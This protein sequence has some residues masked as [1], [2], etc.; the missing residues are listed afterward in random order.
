MEQ[1]TELLDGKG[2]IRLEEVFGNE[3]KIVNAARRAYNR[4]ASEL[5][6]TDI[7]I[8]KGLL[9]NGHTSPLEHVLFTFDVCCPIFVARQWMR[10]R[11]WSFSE[12]SRRYCAEGLEF[13]VPQN[14]NKEMEYKFKSLYENIEKVYKELLNSGIKKE[15]ARSIL[16]VGMYTKFKATVDLNN[17]IKFLAL[18]DE[19]HAQ[20]EI[21][22]YADAIKKLVAPYLPN[23]A[24]ALGWEKG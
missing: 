18:R 12:L 2:Y 6:Q 4:E 3:L 10:H 11:T 24:D 1:I 23:V 8:L 14:V 20:E 21:R 9:T 5:T 16:P 13:Y 19:K 17:L 7:G 15:Q 22:V